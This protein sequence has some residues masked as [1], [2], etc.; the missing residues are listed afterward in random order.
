MKLLVFRSIWGMDGTIEQQITRIAEAGYDG[1]EIGRLGESISVTK[2]TTLLEQNNLKTILSAGIAQRENLRSQLQMMAAYHPLK[3]GLQSGLDYMT[4]HEG[5]QFLEDCLQIE[6]EIGIPVAH[7][8][9]RGRL[10]YTPWATAFYLTQFPTLKVVADFSH[11][12]NVCERL[13]DD[14]QDA[15]Q[16]A[17]TRTIHVHGRVGYEEGPQVPDPS[18]AE[19]STQ[20]NWHENQWR[21]IW[22]MQKTAQVKYFTFTPEY[23]PPPYLHTLPHTGVPVENLWD[24][25]LW[26]AERARSTFT[27][28][29]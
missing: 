14:Q 6:E 26:A 11:W 19:Y 13:P 24:V 17:C 1:V 29:V 15:L 16:L 23:G 10:F 20:L 3:I 4:P 2:L 7:E 9:H 22:Q 5:C 12:V 8:T 27:D 28:I 18:A 21:S 25:C